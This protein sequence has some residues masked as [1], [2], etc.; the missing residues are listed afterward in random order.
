MDILETANTN[1][2]V[3]FN[4]RTEVMRPKSPTT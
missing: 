4:D 3:K 2:A 1:C